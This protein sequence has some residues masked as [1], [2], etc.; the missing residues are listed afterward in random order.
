MSSSS[1][2]KKRSASLS[3]FDVVE[4]ELEE[5]LC[6]PFRLNLKLA[7]DKNAI[8]FRQV[9]DQPGTFTLWQDGRP[10]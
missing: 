10:A 2:W 8:D 5:A 7:S 1:N 3:A 9:L 6:E 4:F